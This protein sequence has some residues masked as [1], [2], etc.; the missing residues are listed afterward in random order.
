[1]GEASGLGISTL[2]RVGREPSWRQ[3]S[4]S[5]YGFFKEEG[6]F[7]TASKEIQ[8]RRSVQKIWSQRKGSSQ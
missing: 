1:M 2:T 4:L 7:G 6:T 8:G 3:T 5:R